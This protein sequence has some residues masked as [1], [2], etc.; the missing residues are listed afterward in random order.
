M[1]L[2]HAMCLLSLISRYTRA[3]NKTIN[4]I[5]DNFFFSYSFS[6]NDYIVTLAEKKQKN[7]LL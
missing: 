2:R 7:S 4:E 5:N 6:L 1:G 3:Y